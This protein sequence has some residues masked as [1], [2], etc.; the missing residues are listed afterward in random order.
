M[1]EDV[2]YE[3]KLLPYQKM[4]V[5]IHPIEANIVFEYYSEGGSVTLCVINNN[6]I[7]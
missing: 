5:E 2:E 6:G 1:A 3:V 4:I 7:C